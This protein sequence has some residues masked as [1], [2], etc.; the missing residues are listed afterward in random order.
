MA[1]RV[2]LGLF[3]GEFSTVN[4]KASGSVCN[5]SSSEGG[6]F[7]HIYS[8]EFLSIFAIL[9]NIRRN[10]K[11]ALICISF[12]AR[13]NG[14]TVWDLFLAI[15]IYSFENS[16]QFN[17]PFF[18][19]NAFLFQELCFLA[20]YSHVS[21]FSHP[22]IFNW[23]SY[24]LKKLP[25]CHTGIVCHLLRGS[26]LFNKCHYLFKS[27]FETLNNFALLSLPYCLFQSSIKFYF[28]SLF[29]L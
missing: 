21:A 6:W 13:D 15:F 17:Y 19:M 20:K 29:S 23:R 24:A 2:D 11:V 14:W 7:S 1:H 28:H 10:L 22:E 5:P 4:S 16:V 26:N 3:F 27:C 18:L 25:H 8:L 12:L 9:T